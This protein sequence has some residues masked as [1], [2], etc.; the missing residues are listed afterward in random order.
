VVQENG[1]TYLRFT[2]KKGVEQ[3]IHIEDK[4]T[5]KML[6]ERAATASERGGKL[7]GVNDSQLRDYSHTLDGGSF[8]PKD[9]RTAKGTS[10]AAEIVKEMKPPT[11]A[12]E[13]KAQ[14]REVAAR[15]S[16]VLGNTPTVA[17]QSYIHPAVF[18]GWRHAA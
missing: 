8:K 5:A 9:F 10:T 15:V 13:Y 14:V 17:L 1:K 3:N 11:N 2:G 16:K 7:F 18:S 4:A 6:T 12:K